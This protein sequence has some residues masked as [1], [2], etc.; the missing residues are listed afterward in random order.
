ME[1]IKEEEGLEGVQDEVINTLNEDHEFLE[2][3]EGADRIQNESLDAVWEPFW[4]QGPEIFKMNLQGQ[5]G[6]D[7]RSKTQKCSK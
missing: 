5:S 7:L 3:D 4:E 1:E 6:S 2:V